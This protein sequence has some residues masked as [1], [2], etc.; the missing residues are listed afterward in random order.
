MQKDAAEALVS[1][2]A[3]MQ[4]SVPTV[5]QLLEAGSDPRLT[6]GE[7]LKPVDL[8]SPSKTEDKS[9]RLLRDAEAVSGMRSSDV[10]G[11]YLRSWSGRKSTAN[12]SS[13]SY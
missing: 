10:V 13:H 5:N 7:G 6:N 8:I 2:M 4:P 1:K 12:A 11:E 9:R 3:Y